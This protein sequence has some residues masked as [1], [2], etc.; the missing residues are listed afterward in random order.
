MGTQLSIAALLDTGAVAVRA[1]W[2][3]WP[4]VVLVG[5]CGELTRGRSPV[6]SPG[7]RAFFTAISI[8]AIL[9]TVVYSSV[10]FYVSQTSTREYFYVLVDVA[11][12]MSPTLVLAVIQILLH[13]CRPERKGDAA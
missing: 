8:V 12:S 6:G 2:F 7:A 9:V 3:I 4:F 13:Y 5:L 1:T 11:T 10:C